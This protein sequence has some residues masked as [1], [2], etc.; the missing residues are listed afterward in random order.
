MSTKF[1]GCT[2]HGAV[3]DPTYDIGDD[4]PL[5]VRALCPT[6][7]EGLYVMRDGKRL[8]P[9]YLRR[10]DLGLKPRTGYWKGGAA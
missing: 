9:K 2:A 5:G 7:G 4:S 8:G 6:C 3:T 10:S 1:T